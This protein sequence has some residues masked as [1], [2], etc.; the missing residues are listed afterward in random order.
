MEDR[1]KKVFSKGGEWIDVLVVTG[2]NKAKFF[3]EA[4]FNLVPG[5][6]GYFIL[7]DRHLE[8]LASKLPKSIFIV[9]FG[10]I[11][12]VVLRFILF[13]IWEWVVTDEMMLIS[14]EK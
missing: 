6:T 1:G 3:S 7:I 2:R 14:E 8:N 5:P 13:S 9:I 4:M 11:E 12:W 10:D